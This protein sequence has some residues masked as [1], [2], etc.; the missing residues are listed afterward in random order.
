MIP[1]T[2]QQAWKWE[3]RAIQERE[4][5]GEV[6]LPLASAPLT[7]ERESKKKLVREIIYG[8]VERRLQRSLQSVSKQT[9]LIAKLP[10]APRSSSPHCARCW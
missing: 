5:K 10:L 8:W 6:K 4:R 1:Q 7:V 9:P 3:H 2:E